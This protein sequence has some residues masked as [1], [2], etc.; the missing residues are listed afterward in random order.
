VKP[1]DFRNQNSLKLAGTQR[2][3]RVQFGCAFAIP[4]LEF[5]RAVFSLLNWRPR[6]FVFFTLH[7]AESFP[8]I[9]VT[10]FRLKSAKP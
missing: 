9:S 10:I 4:R 7:S 2:L 8:F 5:S 1:L 6:Q 3:K